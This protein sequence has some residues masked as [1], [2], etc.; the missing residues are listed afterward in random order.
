[1]PKS[2]P[3]YNYDDGLFRWPEIHIN[4]KYTFVMAVSDGSHVNSKSCTNSWM[5]LEMMLSNK[6]IKFN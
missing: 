2:L 1:M 3:Y 6:T 5:Q 4:V